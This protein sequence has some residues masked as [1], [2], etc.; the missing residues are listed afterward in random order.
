MKLGDLRVLKQN[1]RHQHLELLHWVYSISK[2]FKS[3]NSTVSIQVFLCIGLNIYAEYTSDI[4]SRPR[5]YRPNRPNRRRIRSRL[6]FIPEERGNAASSP[7]WCGWSFWS[8]P[9][10]SWCWFH[11]LWL[12]QNDGPRPI[13]AA[14]KNTEWLKS[15]AADQRL[16]SDCSLQRTREDFSPLI[17]RLLDQLVLFYFLIT[18]F[19]K[20]IRGKVYVFFLHTAIF[21]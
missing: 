3:Q 14:D 1:T 9:P 21:I 12:W 7:S 16:Y 11:T 19:D 17:Q 8:S 10:F 20:R 13:R 2:S 4:S 18:D 5:R 6:T 15:A